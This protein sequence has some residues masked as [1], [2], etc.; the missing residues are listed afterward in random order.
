MPLNH[1]PILLLFICGFVMG[2]SGCAQLKCR[3][4]L[5]VTQ[6]AKSIAKDIQDKQSFAGSFDTVK[7]DAAKNG[8]WLYPGFKCSFVNLAFFKPNYSKSDD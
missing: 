5:G 7:E 3:A 6:D 2:S 1:R 8:F 4:T